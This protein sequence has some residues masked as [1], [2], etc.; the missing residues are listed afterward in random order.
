MGSKIPVSIARDLSGTKV[1][2]FSNTGM[3]EKVLCNLDGK[4]LSLNLDRQVD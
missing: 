1:L 3:F 4:G 2:V